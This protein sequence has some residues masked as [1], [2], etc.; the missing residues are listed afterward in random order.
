MKER[1]SDLAVG[2]AS[3]CDA[4]ESDVEALM[5]ENLKGA[6]TLPFVAFVTHDGKW[7]GGFSGFKDAAAF[8]GVLESA[9]ESP[10]LQATKAVQAKLATLATKATK[11]S[12]AG[13]WKTVVASC[14]EAAKTTG[15][16]PERKTLAGLRKS[17]GAWAAGR[18]DEAVAA[19]RAGDAA[20]A[21]AAIADVRKHFAGEPEADDAD[22]GTKALRRLSLIPAGDAGAPNRAKAAKE[23]EGTRWAAIFSEAR[24]EAPA[25]P[26]PDESG[27]E[28]GD[29]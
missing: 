29:E 23:Y 19:A 20:K 16:C 25:E 12:E 8:V 10:L 6:S 9:E 15:R 17:A 4:P 1:L 11:A 18:F 7:V 3:D 22:T 27:V 28:E 13:D 21:Q 24:A 2:L 14:R 5:R 26:K